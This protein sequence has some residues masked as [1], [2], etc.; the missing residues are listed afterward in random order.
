MV[1]LPF[2]LVVQE[3]S[4]AVVERLGRFNRIC[5]PG[6]HIIMPFEKIA[7]RI[8]LKIQEI[9]VKIE[10]KTLD[11]V[12][13]HVTVAVQYAVMVSRIREAFYELSYPERQ[14]TS[15]VYDEVRAQVPKMKLDD[16]FR[17][18]DDIADAVRKGLTE[19]MN[20][21]GYEIVKSLVTDIDPDPKVKQAM[22]EINAAQRIRRASEERGEAEKILRVK[23]AE[24]EAQASILRGQGIAGQ[25]KAIVD[26][27]RQSVEE[28][29]KSV[30]GTSAAEVMQIVIMTQYFDT[31]KEI[32]GQSKTNTLMI[33]HTPGSI[34]DFS[35]QIR[36][37]IMLGNIASDYVA[38]GGEEAGSAGPAMPASAPRQRTAPPPPERDD[39][40]PRTRPPVPGL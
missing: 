38:R 33:P 18:K 21:Y 22:N 9:P 37:S 7:G 13:V 2:P 15:F 27:L 31:L 29:Q 4:A 40:N 1:P 19:T 32:G 20:Q 11:D 34:G 24:A 16:V 5:P 6:F 39:E 14:I 35:E 28:F 12:F 8:D 26:G 30:P 36:S 25:R 23:Q 17:N 3:K 10:T